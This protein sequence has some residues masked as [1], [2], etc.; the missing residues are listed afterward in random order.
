MTKKLFLLDAM[1]LIYR[2]YYA[3]IRN[4]RLTSKGRNTNAQFGFTNTLFDLINK[5]KPTHLAVCFDTHAPTER[6]TDFSDY[7]A[8]RQDAPEDL[9]ESIPDIQRIIRGFNI[10]VVELD[11][12]E[13]D[14]VIGTVAWQAADKGYDVYM[15][16]PDKDY[17]QLLIHPH[18]YIYKPPYMGNPEEILTA[19]KICSKWDIKRVEQV[20][21]MLGLM[22]DSVDNIPGIAGIGEKTAAKL[23][24]E[25]DTLE[26]ILEN[27][28]SIK[29]AL[30]EKIRNG[31]EAAIMSK[32]LATIITNVPVEFHEE[33]YRLK[34][35]NKDELVTCF[36][37]LEFKTLG[38]R[39][40]GD[41]FNAFHA[42][43]QSIQTDLFGNTVI[44][45][46]ETP[47]KKE[48][49]IAEEPTETAGLFAEK[50]I[51]NTPHQYHLADTTESIQSLVSLLMQQKEICFDTETT[52]TDA[53]NVSLVGL[54][55]SIAPAEGY[56]IPC[57]PDD[58][59]TKNILAQFAPLFAKEDITWVGQNLKYDLLVLKWYG[60]EI[61]GELFDTMLA[62]YLIE[63][64]GR[65]SM[66]LLSAQ[67][68]GYEPVPIEDLIGKKGKNQ[69][70]MRDVPIE[71]IKE[72]AA[73]D[74]DITLQLKHAFVPLL[75]EKE[76]DSV[77][78]KVE[79]PLV[80]V[81]TDMEFEGVKID[82]DFLSQYSTELEKDAK[83]CEEN[84]YE[85]AGV[86]FNL[87]SPKQLGEVL[88][89]KLKLD[90][91][92]KKT[93]TGQYAT[94]E[95]VLLKLANQH[96]IVDDILNFR[97]LT[98]LKSTYVDALPEMINPKTGRVHTSYAQAVAV[99]GRL[100]SNNPNLQNIPI[101]TERGREIRKAFIPREPGRLLLSA[102]YSQIELRIVAAISGDPN[103]CEAFR[104]GKDIHTATAAKVY[105][106]AESEVTKEQRYKAKSVNFGI[107]YGQGAFGL[108]DNLG[109]SRAEAKEIIENYKKEFP[110][111]QRYMDDKINFAKE[112]GYVQT[113]AGRKRW[114]KDI[115]SSNF[116][117]RGY[118]ERN[119]INSPIQ[120]TAADMIK[121]AMISVHQ[122]MKKKSWQSK[123][124]L[125]VHDELVF[126]AVPEEAED[127]KKLIIHCM[128][129]AMPLPNEVPV[130]AEV[131]QGQNWLEAH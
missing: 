111:I 108:A 112:H 129:T 46:T 49:N 101:R 29:G 126:D 6:H 54:S 23:L 90:P 78:E 35:W 81:L 97:E 26:N 75:Q 116:T 127:L 56:Y 92:A 71:K 100:S 1:A 2:A 77:F 25:Y 79:N 27:A 72:Y 14:D 44:S 41:E 80:R 65:R 32:K 82:V 107:I 21:D 110:N 30:G 37:E 48:K 36:T 123:M 70:N 73:E 119:A 68:L 59:A 18:V 125:Q 95:D 58:A 28:D 39:I 96:K 104:L 47:V 55:F 17:G 51:T 22:G 7:K 130:E 74:A 67:Y 89:E 98:K 12:Y 66:D 31:R 109:I 53:N 8:N 85:Q 118:A 60:I 86:R 103:M 124:I 84:V 57:P 117:V 4:P 62:H 88:F 11:G 93:K 83:R 43:P 45:K 113:L 105:G 94:G 20:I 115:N 10:P 19:E 50:N 61:K 91:K 34:E 5:E 69:G 3:L 120:G 33:D 131:G 87:A 15:V 76:L 114:L 128:T 99:T 9:L 16:T 102:D 38:K 121:L 64:E 40:L 106:I 122:E 24:K 13:A 63:P 52:G 42:A